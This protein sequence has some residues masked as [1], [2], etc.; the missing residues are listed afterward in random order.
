MV[1]K[2]HNP[3]PEQRLAK[4]T[5]STRRNSKDS[6]ATDEPPEVTEMDIPL[7]ASPQASRP[8]TPENADPRQ[9]HCDNLQ[10]LT[11]LVNAYSRTIETSQKILQGV[12]SSGITDP[13]HPIIQMET[14]YLELN[15]SR[16]QKAVS[17]YTSL[18]PC[19]I[20]KCPRHDIQNT[21]LNPN[22]RGPSTP[23]PIKRKEDTE[24]FT[25]PPSRKLTK[26]SNVIP[27][28]N[29]KI[30]L[31]NAFSALDITET[32]EPIE[33]QV[34]TNKSPVAS[35]SK[36]NTTQ[37]PK[38]PPPIMLL[39]TDELRM[40]TTTLTSKM[41]I[42]RI[43]AA[44]NYV[45]LYTDTQPQH[46][47]LKQLLTELKYPFYSFT[48]KHERPIKVVIKGLP[49]TTKTTEIQSDL[50]DLGYTINKVTQLTGNITKQPL[51]V[52]TIS[53]PRNDFNMN[54]FNLKTLGYLSITVEGFESRGVIQCFQCNQFNH[55]AEHCHLTPKCLKCGENHQTRDCQIKMLDTRYCVNC[56]VHGHMANYSKCPLFPKPRKGA[57]INS[58]SILTNNFIRPNISYAQVTQK[59]NQS[60]TTHQMAPLVTAPI[61]TQT[62][63]EIPTPTIVS[64]QIPN[65]QTDCLNLITQTLQQTIHALATLVQNISLMTSQ[66]TVTAQP[67]PGPAKTTSKSPLTKSQII[68]QI[69]NLLNHYDGA[70][71]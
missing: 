2:R 30:N 3:I 43:K 28:S 34:L 67:T 59:T 55:T 65:T 12:I 69:N 16:L 62:I 8:G 4:K 36:T 13:T 14:P 5:S 63:K 10:R 61:G 47:T 46:D 41:P 56:K 48:P 20:P 58:K 64:S 18:P 49:R 45:K 26:N 15:N 50:L 68:A 25:T 54:I 32:D 60:D 21:P 11:D 40:H 24:G 7:P 44:G 57:N 9:L 29:F 19:G 39:I 71:D 6:T 42:L 22:A 66:Q 27:E 38:L 51:S 53:L 52:F 23:T 1:R 31:N 37:P 70:S 33:S 17:E 35:P